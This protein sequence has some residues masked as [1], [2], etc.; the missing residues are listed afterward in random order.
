MV[1]VPLFPDNGSGQFAL[2]GRSARLGRQR[3]DPS[4]LSRALSG[5]SWPCTRLRAEEQG[6]GLPD[7]SQGRGEERPGEVIRGGCQLIGGHR[8]E[9][10][11]AC[12]TASAAPIQRP[13]TQSSSARA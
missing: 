10:E 4:Y 7:G 13:V 8:A 12:Q 2:G 5:P 1:S 3:G 9:R 11:P 6:L